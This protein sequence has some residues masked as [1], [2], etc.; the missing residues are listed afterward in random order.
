MD[1][2]LEVVVGDLSSIKVV[3]GIDEL[4]EQYRHEGER[5][6]GPNCCDSPE[7]IEER[8]LDVA[9]PKESLLR[10]G[11]QLKSSREYRYG[12]A[13]HAHSVYRRCCRFSRH[14]CV[15]S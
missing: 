3:E 14:S 4:L 11:R 10:K 1:I 9:I 2:I 5:S 13:D 6:S 7:A 12:G 8:L 15:E